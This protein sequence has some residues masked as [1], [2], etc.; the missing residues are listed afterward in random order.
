M[1]ADRTER[2]KGG[3]DSNPEKCGR[4][5]PRQDHDFSNADRTETFPRRRCNTREQSHQGNCFTDSPKLAAM[6]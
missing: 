5:Q 6:R 2:W 3:R 1:L 4:H